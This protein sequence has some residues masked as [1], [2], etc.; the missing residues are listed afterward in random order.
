MVFAFEIDDLNF[1]TFFSFKLKVI[2]VIIIIIF[3]FLYTALTDD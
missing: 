2:S 1:F 3:S